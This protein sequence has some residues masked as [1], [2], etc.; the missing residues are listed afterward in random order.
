MPEYELFDQYSTVNPSPAFVL[1]MS[2]A[3]EEVPLNVP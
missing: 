1:P 3:I 2:L